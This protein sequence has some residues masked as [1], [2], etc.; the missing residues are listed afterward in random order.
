MEL[1]G[2]MRL[3]RVEAN[4]GRGNSD[5][6]EQ[7]FSCDDLGGANHRV[8][9][10][11]V[12]AEALTEEPAC[13]RTLRAEAVALV[14]H[15]VVLNLWLRC[16]AND[17]EGHEV[18]QLSSARLLKLGEQ[19]LGRAHHPKVDV[20]RGARAVEAQLEHET[21]FERGCISEHAVDA[22]E[23]SVKDE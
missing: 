3:D 15:A 2:Q 1:F 17:L 12:D 10:S 6:V 22:R 21:S 11:D 19:I 16:I 9:E 8:S 23:K 13:D 18:A 20:L 14:R 5:E 7:V 4:G